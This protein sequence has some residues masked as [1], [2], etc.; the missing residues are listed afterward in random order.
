MG[1]QFGAGKGGLFAGGEI[2]QE[3]GVVLQF[4]VAGDEAEVGVLAV[5]ELE[6]GLDGS[7]GEVHV[8]NKAGL[9]KSLHELEIGLAGGGAVG[10]EP[11]KGLGAAGQFDL[12]G[13][14]GQQQAFDA[15]AEA[16]AGRRAA[17]ELFDEVV[18]ASPPP[19]AF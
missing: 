3:E 1:N 12:L 13:F 8:G 15:G 10:D 2:F 19:M 4:G 9:A 5:G 6:L 16:D 7:A 14:E 11:E 17:A 18:V